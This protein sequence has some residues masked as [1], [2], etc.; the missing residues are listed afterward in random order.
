MSAGQRP[1]TR[2][3]S[4]RLAVSRLT[5][6]VS[7]R[8]KRRRT[9]GPSGLQRCLSKPQRQT[10]TAWMA[11]IIPALPQAPPKIL[12]CP[13]RPPLFRV[14]LAHQHP[15][16]RPPRTSLGKVRTQS[17][18]TTLRGTLISEGGSPADVVIVAPWLTWLPTHPPTGAWAVTSTEGALPSFRP[19]AARRPA[20]HAHAHVRRQTMVETCLGRQAD[21]SHTVQGASEF[22]GVEWDGTLTFS[23]DDDGEEG[24][25][26]ARPD[27]RLDRQWTT[28][29][30][31]HDI[32][33]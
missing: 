4:R 19:Q 27:L 21:F 15:P 2:P 20:D 30:I 8:T 28:R 10:L 29:D 25:T 12:P 33:S 32:Q 17:D 22:G 23:G 24:E 3:M 7:R 13:Q 9:P 26:R 11:D 14:F 18:R 16:R 6:T 5:S 1:S 31:P